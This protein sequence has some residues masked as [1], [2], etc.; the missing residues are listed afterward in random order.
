MA[1]AIARCRAPSIPPP[2]TSPAE[3]VTTT[4]RSTANGR[5]ITRTTWTRLLKK[6]ETRAQAGAAAGGGRA[7]ELEVGIIA[8]GTSHWA[9]VESRDQLRE[10]HNLETDYLR[11]RAYP[12]PRRCKI[13]SPLTSASTWWSR[14]AT[15]NAESA[16]DRICRAEL[17]DKLR[18]VRNCM[19][20]R[21]TPAP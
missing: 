14:T 9:I 12:F 21:S 5:T 10:E 18:S 7:R 17:V 11:V 3:A 6:F 13:L 4:R 8:Y 16:E 15:R 1:L 20:C 2:P 19:G